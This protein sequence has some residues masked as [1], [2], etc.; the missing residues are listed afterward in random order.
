LCDAFCAP[1]TTPLCSVDASCKDSCTKAFQSAG[2]CADELDAA[3]ACYN[4]NADATNCW[5]ND[6]CNQKIKTYGDCLLQGRACS[7][8]SCADNGLSCECQVSCGNNLLE[9]ACGFYDL[10]WDCHCKVNGMALGKCGD[11]GLSG[12][13]CDPFGGCCKNLF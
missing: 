3:V 6:D 2:E 10:S 12:G 8:T 11:Q 7:P 5:L 9:T 4:A 1:K 13:V